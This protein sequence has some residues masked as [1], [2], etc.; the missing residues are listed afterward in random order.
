MPYVKQTAFRGLDPRT[1]RPDVDPEK[2]PAT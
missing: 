1:G 2:K